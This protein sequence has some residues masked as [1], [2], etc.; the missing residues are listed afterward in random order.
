VADRAGP[1]WAGRA[2]GVQNIGQNL[3]ASLAPPAVGALISASGY[4]TAFACAAV[5][6]LAAIAVVPVRAVDG[7][8]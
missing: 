1:L 4:G 7:A 3:T 6:G 2:L 5:C 8:A